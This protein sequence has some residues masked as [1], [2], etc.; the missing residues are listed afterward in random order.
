MLSIEEEAAAGAPVPLVQRCNLCWN[1][2]CLSGSGQCFRTTC[3]HIFCESCA[4][5]HF[6]EHQTCPS[7]GRELRETDVC[8]VSFG[9]PPSQDFTS[10]LYQELYKEAGLG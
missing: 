9:L 10:S 5:N 3:R 4:Y 1:G 2:V 6:G 8:E 7:C